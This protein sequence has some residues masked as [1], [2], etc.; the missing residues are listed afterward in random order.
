MAAKRCGC[1][2]TRAQHLTPPGEIDDGCWCP[3]CLQR[4]NEDRCRSY[5]PVLSVDLDRPGVRVGHAH[6]ETAKRA[7]GIASLRAGSRRK[8]V[9]DAI[10][11][12]LHRGFT[13]DEMETALGRSHQTLS[14]TR[15]SL[16]NDGLIVDSGQRRRTK[17]GNDAIVWVVAG[18][19]PKP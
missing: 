1:G 14:A 2:G 6:P 10:Q 19:P 7:A 8:E 5:D 12:T 17:W 16:M 18:L 9:Y 13:D 11:R 3:R 4:P 15:N